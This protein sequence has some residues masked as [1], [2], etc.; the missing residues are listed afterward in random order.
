MSSWMPDAARVPAYRD[1]G[2]LELVPARVVWIRSD[3]VGEYSAALTANYANANVLAPHLIWN[4]FSGDVIQMLPADRRAMW[5]RSEGIQIVVCGVPP[6][7]S[8]PLQGNAVESLSGLS[9]VM[10]WV[11]SL[12]VPDFSPLGP[13]VPTMPK[14]AGKHAGHYSSE[15][16]ID[17]DRLLV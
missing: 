8:F 5:L 2:P 16:K 3:L 9:G 10:G 4:P 11:R 1:A 15:G 7:G 17:V 6:E 12:D 13:A 14:A